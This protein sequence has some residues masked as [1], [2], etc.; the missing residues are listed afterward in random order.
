METQV[1]EIMSSIQGE[2]LTVGLRQ[3]FLRFLGC[4]LRCRYCDTPN[5]LD[6]QQGLCQVEKTPGRRDFSYLPNPLNEE[7]ILGIIKDLEVNRRHHSLS[8]TGGEPL[9]QVD[10][11]EGFLPQLKEKGLPVY[12]ETNGT[13]MENLVRI[14]GQLDYIGMDIKLPSSLDGESCW[15]EH[16]DFLEIAQQKEVFVKIILTAQTKE[17]EILQSLKLIQEIKRS[18]PLVFQPVSPWGG[19]EAPEPWRV[20]ELQDLALE[21]LDQVRVIPQTHKM[22]GQL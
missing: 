16:A 10:F 11:L 2:G 4:N 15:N 7:Q 3:I 6:G 1:V 13:L 21:Y 22:M 20:I 9:L 19:L 8:L 12:L 18:I 17:E 5:S 14:I